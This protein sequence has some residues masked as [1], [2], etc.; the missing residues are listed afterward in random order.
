MDQ[1]EKVIVKICVG[2]ACFVQGGADLLLYN[3]FLNPEVLE[4]CEIEGSSCLEFC[5]CGGG[6]ADGEGKPPFISINGKVH[7]DVDEERFCALLA[8]AVDARD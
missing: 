6:K 1:K 8:E 2:T 5:K 7:G 4:E 3:D